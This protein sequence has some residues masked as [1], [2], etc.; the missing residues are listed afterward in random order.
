MGFITPFVW[1]F[2]SSYERMRK[3]LLKEKI[4]VH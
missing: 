3:K 1:M 2:I 4:L